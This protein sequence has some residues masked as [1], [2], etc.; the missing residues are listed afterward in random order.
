MLRAWGQFPDLLSIAYSSRASD[1]VFWPPRYERVCT[2]ACKHTCIHTETEI[3]NYIHR[4]RERYTC[5]YRE[6]ERHRHAHRERDTHTHI[7]RKTHTERKTHTQRLY[8][9]RDI[10]SWK[11][12]IKPMETSHQ[13]PQISDIWERPLQVYLVG[14][15]HSRASRRFGHWLNPQ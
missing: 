6:T 8:K 5:T 4:Y 3:Y 13:T 15:L 14:S 2:S 10:G 11:A 9:N 7:Q 1:S 12:S